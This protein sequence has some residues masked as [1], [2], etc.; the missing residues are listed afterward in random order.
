VQGDATS[1]SLSA[2]PFGTGANW[3]DGTIIRLVGQ[4]NANTV[5][6]TNNDAANGMILN[7]SWIGGYGDQLT[8]QYD[9]SAERWFEVERNN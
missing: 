2:T 5:T 1:I 8:V 3:P 4:S 7:G 9:S 6:A